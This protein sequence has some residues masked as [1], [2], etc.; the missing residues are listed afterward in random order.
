MLPDFTLGFKCSLEREA[1]L[2]HE[3]KGTGMVGRDRRGHEASDQ[4]QSGM[5]WNHTPEEISHSSNYQPSQKLVLGK[6]AAT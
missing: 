6:E 1:V 4:T 2:G 3:V 5:P